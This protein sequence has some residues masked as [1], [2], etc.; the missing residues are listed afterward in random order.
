V[1]AERK[2]K[3]VRFPVK[4][5]ASKRLLTFSIFLVSGNEQ[6]LLDFLDFSGLKQEKLKN[7]DISFINNKS[8][9]L[10]CWQPILFWSCNKKW[11]R[12]VRKFACNKGKDYGWNFMKSK[13][14]F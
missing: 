9:C 4:T 5:S 13:E 11:S 12:R 7:F 3:I 14:K 8:T 2:T 6:E 10:P 1:T